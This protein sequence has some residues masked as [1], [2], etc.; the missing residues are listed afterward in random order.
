M[1]LSKFPSSDAKEWWQNFKQLLDDNNEWPGEYVFK[2]IAPKEN[3]SDVKEVF[4][5]HD[6]DIKASSK[7]SY[8]SITSR[9]RVSSSDEII[10]IYQKA[11]QV[12]GVISL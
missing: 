5:G 7:G 3:V 12:E 8:H 1:A 10:E 6:I 11:G 2:F 4:I 9:I